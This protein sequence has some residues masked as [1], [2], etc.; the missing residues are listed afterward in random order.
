M[1]SLAMREAITIA[2]ACQ[3]NHPLSFYTSNL[4]EILPITDLLDVHGNVLKHE[5]ELSVTFSSCLQD[6]YT[7]NRSLQIAHYK[8]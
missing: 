7:T 6:Q 8:F 1:S 5:L 2:L 4:P 3:D